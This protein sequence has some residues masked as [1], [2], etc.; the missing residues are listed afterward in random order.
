MIHPPLAAPIL[1]SR[2]IAASENFQP[3]TTPSGD[4]A[5]CSRVVL[6]DFYGFV[7]RVARDGWGH[8]TPLELVGDATNG[9]QALLLTREMEPDLVVLDMRLPDHD[10]LHLLRQLLEARPTLRI[11]LFG[12]PS[13]EDLILDAMRAGAWGYLPK[14]TQPG[15]LVR[16]M[17]G[18][19]NGEIA[20][21]RRMAAR[22]MQHFRAAQPAPAPA[23]LIKL[24]P[25]EQRVMVLLAEGASDRE[26][27]ARLVIAESTA[28]KHVQHILRKLRARNRAEAVAKYH[29]PKR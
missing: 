6:V 11:L 23:P 18:I 4:A 26:I 28:K 8:D 1:R 24:T 10:A 14:E 27:A 5:A 29:P 13:N 9:L 7:R 2:S 20:L 16:A 25:A 15:A 22:V 12:G 21:S 3:R 19:A 17:I